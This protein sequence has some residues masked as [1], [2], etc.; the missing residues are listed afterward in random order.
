MSETIEK[1]NAEA[2]DL[3]S[4]VLLT[5]KVG[6]HEYKITAKDRFMDNG[7]CVQLLTQSKENRD[8]GRRATPILSREA[9]RLIGKFERVHVPHNYGSSVEVY[10]LQ[11]GDNSRHEQ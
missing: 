7:A 11:N 6:R 10:S 5:I 4:L 9:I 8:W 3:D 2:V 1:P